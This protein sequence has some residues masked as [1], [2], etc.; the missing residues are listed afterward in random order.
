MSSGRA[1][2]Y[3]ARVFARWQAA[4]KR[5]GILS[6]KEKRHRPLYVRSV[7]GIPPTGQI[8]SNPS[9]TGAHQ[10][11]KVEQMASHGSKK[12]NVRDRALVPRARHLPPNAESGD[13]SGSPDSLEKPLCTKCATDSEAGEEKG[14]GS[15]PP[16]GPTGE[17]GTRAG[18][19]QPKGLIELGWFEGMPPTDQSILALEPFTGAFSRLWLLLVTWVLS[20]EA[21]APT[22]WRI[23]GEWWIAGVIGDRRVSSQDTHQGQVVIGYGRDLSLI[24]KVDPWRGPIDMPGG[25]AFALLAELE[26]WW[27]GPEPGAP[28][29]PM[30]S[31]ES[32][33]SVCGPFSE[34]WSLICRLLLTGNWS[35]NHR[36]FGHRL[37]GKETSDGSEEEGP[38]V[39]GADGGWIEG[40]PP[41]LLVPTEPLRLYWYHSGCQFVQRVR[42]QRGGQAG[43][44]WDDIEG[45]CFLVR[46]RTAEGEVAVGTIEPWRQWLDPQRAGDLRACFRTLLEDAGVKP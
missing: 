41:T 26:D 16:S 33:E 32:V 29:S 38:F 34:L 46:E 18:D 15:G 37:F 12:G 24:G 1:E 40:D 31:L 20:H 28:A 5:R 3:W 11:G 10:P 9:S 21:V 7:V 35:P 22:G 43:H 23:F 45:P 14:E 44:N 39:S 30:P 4:H 42:G 19:G 2:R 8:D 13:N 25:A 36:L 27:K 6:T 17:T